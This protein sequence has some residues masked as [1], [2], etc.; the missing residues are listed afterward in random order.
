M[1]EPPAQKVKVSA[2]YVQC[3]AE[4]KSGGKGRGRSER[5]VGHVA[6]GCPILEAPG[7]DPGPPEPCS[8]VVGEL[9]RLVLWE[10]EH[11]M[12]CSPVRS[13]H[14]SKPPHTFTRPLL[15]EAPSI[16]CGSHLHTCGQ[17]ALERWD[18]WLCSAG[19][20]GNQDCAPPSIKANV[21]NNRRESEVL[22]FQGKIQ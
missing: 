20:R 18:F 16:S 14:P 19:Q 2:R 17:W 7:C 1:R 5:S 11:R 15:D 10:S 6:R 12:G 13:S 21:H 8:P 3:S 22:G 9:A 4:R